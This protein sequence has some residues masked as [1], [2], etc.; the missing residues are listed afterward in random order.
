LK[1]VVALGTKIL[2]IKGIKEIS[3]KLLDKNVSEEYN[4]YQ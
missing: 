1:K 3:Q 2:Q 4:I